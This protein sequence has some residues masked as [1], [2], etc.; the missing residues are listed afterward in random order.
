MMFCHRLHSPA[1]KTSVTGS[2]VQ[3][4]WMV[5]PPTKCRVTGIPSRLQLEIWW[6]TINS[7]M[8]TAYDW[9]G[10]IQVW[11]C[12]M[13]SLSIAQEGGKG[14]GVKP[15]LGWHLANLPL[16]VW[17]DTCSFTPNHSLNSHSNT[18]VHV[19]F[20][21]VGCCFCWSVEVWNMCKN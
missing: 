10:R 8:T 3:N 5:I 18:Q 14:V 17:R 19:K 13:F 11:D 6:L 4:T 20:I 16:K 12:Y 7:I 2:Q 1:C 21:H 9:C 15:L